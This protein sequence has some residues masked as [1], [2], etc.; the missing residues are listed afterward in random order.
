MK[1]PGSVDPLAFRLALADY[2]SVSHVFNPGYLPSATTLPTRSSVGR[3]ISI[4]RDKSKFRTALPHPSID[5]HFFFRQNILR[6]VRNLGFSNASRSIHEACSSWRRSSH[7]QLANGS[8]T[9]S[10]SSFGT[11]IISTALNGRSLVLRP[12][13]SA[14]CASG[15]TRS[16]GSTEHE[17][18]DRCQVAFI[19]RS[20]IR[21]P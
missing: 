18:A 20:F 4:M 5:S 19:R 2:I 3:M 7:S 8:P 9:R 12:S 15:A 21:R 1:D 14:S 16:A 11:S 17:I 10:G 13:F 6:S